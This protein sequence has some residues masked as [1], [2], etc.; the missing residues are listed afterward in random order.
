MA[1][2][3]WSLEYLAWFGAILNSLKNIF[4]EITIVFAYK[5]ILSNAVYI[6]ENRFAPTINFAFC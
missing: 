6:Y 4:C 5:P 2:L 3:C 1:D